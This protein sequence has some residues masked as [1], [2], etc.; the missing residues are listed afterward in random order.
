MNET[1]GTSRPTTS[2]DIGNATFSQALAAGHTHLGW[3][4]GPTTAKS[5]QARALASH[6][7]SPE[8][9]KGSRTN[10]TFGPLFG[11]S[12]PSASLQSC[13]ESRLRQRLAVSGSPEYALTWKR[14]VMRSG[15]P[16]CALRASG[17]RTSGSG[18]GG[19]PT[20]RA[21]E[22]GPDYAIADRKGSGGY[23][24]QTVAQIAGWPTPTL[25][26]SEQAGGAGC[27]ARGGRGHSLHSA[28]KI[29]GWATPQA[30]DHRRGETGGEPLTH[31]S[32]P[33]SEQV[34]LADSGP[35]PP[36]SPAATEKR[37]ALNPAHSRWL[38]GYPPAWDDCAATATP[39]TPGSRLSS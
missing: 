5:G 10:A 18:C 37:G 28:A 12:S 21:A 36:G 39:L 38:M 9:A 23:S 25:Q 4:D 8:R 19:W 26:D 34:L 29:S 13:L 31:N 22:A 35:T 7:A 30:R 24:L 15:P 16:I 2:G 14:W 6:S 20:P 33:L 1:S 32:R 3:L 17:R 11:G 27:I